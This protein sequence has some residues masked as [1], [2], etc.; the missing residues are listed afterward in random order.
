VAVT[1]ENLDA[2]I[3]WTSGAQTSFSMFR[4][5]GRYSLIRELHE[6]KLTTFEIQQHL[7]AG[8][9]ST[10]QTVNL[11]LDRIRFIQQKLGLKPHRVSAG[12]IPLGKKAAELKREGRSVEWI[13]HHLNEQG[14]VSPRGKWWTARIVYDLMAKVG[15]KVETL[16][17][18]HRRAIM[19]ARACGLSYR[20]MAIEFNE[21]RVPRRKDCHR[22]WTERNLAHTWSKLNLRYKRKE[23]N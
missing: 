13:A 4:N 22:P 19:E 21:K 23:K 8:K 14:F 7:A 17:D 5:A 1:K 2:I 6:Q 3:F 11:S 10:G 16:G 15:E 20:E 18:L 9:T 12:T